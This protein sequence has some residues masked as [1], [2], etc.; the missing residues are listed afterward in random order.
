MLLDLEV[1][2]RPHPSCR[3]YP[4]RG[5]VLPIKVYA[6]NWFAYPIL[7]LYY[8]DLKVHNEVCE[9]WRAK[10]GSEFTLAKYQLIHISRK[11]NINYA[12]GLRLQ[13]G[14]LTKGANTAVSLG[15]TLQSKLSWKD[16]ISKV[17]KKAVKSI[18][19]LSSI[20]GLTLGSNYLPLRRIFKAVIIPQ[21]TYGA[22][23]W[24]TPTGEKG[25]RKTLIM[26]LAQAQ[27]MG[28]R[29][30]TGAFRATSAQALNIEA[31]L[32]PIGLELNKR[33]D[34]TAVR[35]C[36]GPLYHT[37]IQSRSTHSR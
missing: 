5:R 28:A 36:S 2:C 20:V 22:S 3:Q 30:I 17:K 24:H 11:R 33:T 27:A 4:M 7:R 18:G 1:L 12:A 35:L 25:S 37:L 19:A 16:H 8:L 9:S 15:I 26:Q 29:L 14:Q 23:I 13:G 32:T 31:H 6:S 10:H 34:Q 21:I